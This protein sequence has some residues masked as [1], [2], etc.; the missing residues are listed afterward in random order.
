[1]SIIIDFRGYET[2]GENTVL[3]ASILGAFAVLRKRGRKKK[4]EEDE[5]R[6]GIPGEF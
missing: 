4:E 6:V 2:L 5:A 3:F 1:M